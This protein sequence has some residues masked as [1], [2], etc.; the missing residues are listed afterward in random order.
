VTGLKMFQF[1]QAQV[2]LAQPASFGADE[3]P[4]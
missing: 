2:T 1:R 4:N 3:P